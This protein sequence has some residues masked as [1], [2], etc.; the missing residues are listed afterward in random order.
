MLQ[1]LCINFI[2]GS[3]NMWK[4]AC[5]CLNFRVRFKRLGQF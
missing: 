1:H 2:E 5:T 4:E 3:I